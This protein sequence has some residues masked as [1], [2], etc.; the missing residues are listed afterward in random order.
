MKPVGRHLIKICDGTACHVKG[1]V[2]VIDAMKGDL[3]LGDV[4]TTKDGLF[5]L[6][7]VACL[8]CCSLAPVMMVDDTTYGELTI[9]KVREIIDSYRTGGESNE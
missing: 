6:E 7:E 1:S 4:D 9:E 3:E 2:T 8:G 5:T